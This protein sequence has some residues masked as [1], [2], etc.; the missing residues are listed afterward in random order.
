LPR[1]VADDNAHLVRH[2]RFTPLQL[3]SGAE[4]PAVT[5][6]GIGGLALLHRGCRLQ[7]LVPNA[8]LAGSEAVYGASLPEDALVNGWAFTTPTRQP[9]ELDPVCKSERQRVQQ[10]EHYLHTRLLKSD[11]ELQRRI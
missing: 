11:K 6:N 4:G 1:Q 5:A 2:V 8:S 10:G 3:R 7:G 9:Q